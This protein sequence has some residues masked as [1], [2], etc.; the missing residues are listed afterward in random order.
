MSDAV[1]RIRCRRC[2]LAV[3]YF[4]EDA[5]TMTIR[6]NCGTV[7]VTFEPDPSLP[8]PTIDDYFDALEDGLEM[9]RSRN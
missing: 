7:S 4:D 9:Y 1:G 2:G 6:C 8:S 5:L 3:A